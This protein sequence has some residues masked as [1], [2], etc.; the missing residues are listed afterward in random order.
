[1][2]HQQK[3]LV[4]RQP[5]EGLSTV[6]DTDSSTPPVRLHC[7]LLKLA[8]GVVDPEEELVLF[9]WRQRMHNA[10]TNTTSATPATSTDS[11]TDSS[12]APIRLQC[13]L[14]KLAGGLVSPEEGVVLCAWRQRLH[15]AA[16]ADHFI[17]SI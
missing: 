16:T 13:G 1:M 5:E 15:N 8:G 14:H 6:D 12:T 9:T 10:S 7:R 2:V 17:S 4:L 3:S 11:S